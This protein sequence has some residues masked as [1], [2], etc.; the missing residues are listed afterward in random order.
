MASHD[1]GHGQLAVLRPAFPGPGGPARRHFQSVVCRRDGQMGT[2]SHFPLSAFPRL[3]PH[4]SGPILCPASPRGIESANL[5][6]RSLP[7][8]VWDPTKSLLLSARAAWARSTA[9]KTPSW[10]RSRHKDSARRV[11]AR[12]RPHGPLR[13]RGA[14]ARVAESSQHRPDL[15]DRRSRL[16]ME[17]V[18][19]ETLKGPLP[20]E[21]RC[22]S[23]GRSPTL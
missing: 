4:L 13:A 2:F 6:W 8:L 21:K 16:V 7:G 14:G 1:E 18:E 19:G 20:L 15:R 12:S 9:P 5:L 11:R 10:P 3:N 17:L 22:T 23:P